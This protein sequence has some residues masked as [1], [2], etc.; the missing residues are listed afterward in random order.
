MA[1]LDDRVWVHPKWR[2]LGDAAYRVGTYAICYSHGFGT[3][4]YLNPVDLMTIGATPALTEELLDVGLWEPA[5]ENS[6]EPDP[7]GHP[8]VTLAV[9]V[10]SRGIVIHDWDNY[11]DDDADAKRREKNAERQ[12]RSRAHRAGHISVTDESRDS[13]ADVAP[14]ERDGHADV[15]PSRARA[16]AGFESES[17]SEVKDSPNPAKRGTRASGQNPRA[18]GT[19]PR[20]VAKQN[21]EELH[22]ALIAAAVAAADTWEPSGTD[23]VH[24]RLDELERELGA[25]FNDMERIRI[26][27]HCVERWKP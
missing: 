25:R 13:H 17:E 1:F 6:S 18:L 15:T 2:L 20:A 22:R 19:N 7:L 14:S 11:N 12:R 16:R 9:T 24:E 23:V 8:A 21:R 10:E 27:D 4:G 3:R 26:V 5:S